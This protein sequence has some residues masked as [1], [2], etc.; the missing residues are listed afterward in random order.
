MKSPEL[1]DHSCRIYV[2]FS[3]RSEDDLVINN[4]AQTSTKGVDYEMAALNATTKG[5]DHAYLQ[6]K[7]MN[8]T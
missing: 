3:A 4:P 6:R 1:E 2:A 5:E 7:C 8:V